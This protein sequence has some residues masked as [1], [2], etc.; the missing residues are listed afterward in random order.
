MKIK[1]ILSALAMAAIAVSCVNK[2]LDLDKLD[3]EITVVPGLTATVE[4]NESMV[5]KLDNVVKNDPDYNPALEKYGTDAQGNYNP[6]LL[7]DFNSSY[8]VKK[9]FDINKHVQGLDEKIKTLTAIVTIEVENGVAIPFL[10]TVEGD[11]E[12]AVS[13]QIPAKGKSTFDVKYN[14]VI[15]VK[16]IE[17]TIST[18]Y[19]KGTQVTLNKNDEIKVTVKKAIISIPDGIT[20]KL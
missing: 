9:D 19:K 18:T 1:L 13:H 10:A 5:T 8:D 12:T 2:D 17:A 3:T 6:A 7:P 16:E 20:V 11:G 14:N 15:N 4:V